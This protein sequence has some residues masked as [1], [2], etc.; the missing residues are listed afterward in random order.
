MSQV[1][2]KYQVLIDDQFSIDLP[3]GAQ[4]LSVGVQHDR[5]Y[6]WVL[7]DPG[8]PLYRR[9]F[10]VATTGNPLPPGCDKF[11]GTFQLMGGRFI[12]HL[13]ETA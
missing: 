12:G 7:Q 9:L 5:P 1:I 13:F 3:K 10:A 11:I 4:V 8:A 6:V 2:Y